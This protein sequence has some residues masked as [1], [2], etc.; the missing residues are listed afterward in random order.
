MCETSMG[1]EARQDM[2]IASVEEPLWIT[3]DGREIPVK[4]LK[5][6]HL[7]NVIKLLLRHAAVGKAKTT[8]TYLD[9]PG[10]LGDCALDCFA[11]E[12]NMILDSEVTDYVPE[13]FEILWDEFQTRREGQ[14]DFFDVTYGNMDVYIDKMG[15]ASMALEI[16]AMVNH[17]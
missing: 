7:S 2:L 1:E 14:E 6:D 3:N 16:R 12:F 10:E 8:I 9:G 13:I 15:N 4:N 5:T 17:G 11:Q